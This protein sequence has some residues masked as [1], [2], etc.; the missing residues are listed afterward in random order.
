MDKNKPQKEKKKLFSGLWQKLKAT[1]YT[2]YILAGVLGLVVIVIFL[3]SCST[4]SKNKSASTEKTATNTE[5][6]SSVLSYSE[7]LEH[8]LE[9]VLESVKGC[10]NV[11]VMVVAESSP[12]I[13]LAEQIEEKTTGSGENKV[14]TKYPVYVEN[15]SSKTP[16]ILY[17]TAPKVNGVLIVAKGAGNAA[18][19]LKIITALQALL[20]IDASKIEV[21]EGA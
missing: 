10:S 6:E 9:N 17:Q 2:E 13:V 19:K 20:G 18:V 12:T 1:K 5:N 8:K 14:I 15:G 11:K 4:K 16:M 3:S 7:A 21:L